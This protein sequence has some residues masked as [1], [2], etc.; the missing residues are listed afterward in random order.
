[1]FKDNLWK[2]KQ[3][4]IQKYAKNT[5]YNNRLMSLD[6]LSPQN[7]TIN[8]HVYVNN[9]NSGEKYYTIPHF[10]QNTHETRLGHKRIASQ[11]E[12]K[13]PLK[14]NFD[15]NVLADDPFGRRKHSMKHNRIHSFNNLNKEIIPQTQV[16]FF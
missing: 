9:H 11:C 14:P 16:N 5:K 3:T 4:L 15:N 12:M 1:M 6:F 13:I 2:Q 10:Q 7:I 8:E